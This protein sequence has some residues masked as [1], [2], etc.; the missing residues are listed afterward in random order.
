MKVVMSVIALLM[1]LLVSPAS[2]DTIADI[3]IARGDTVLYP[4]WTA[5]GGVWDDVASAGLCWNN[6]EEF[7]A[8]MTW[9]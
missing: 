9:P 7:L 6:N 4:P 5:G 3:S 2:S 8:G 1:V